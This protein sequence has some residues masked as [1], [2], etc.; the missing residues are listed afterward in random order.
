MEE[1]KNEGLHHATELSDASESD[2]PV[3]NGETIPVRT[4][5]RRLHK[6][7]T[8]Y[9]VTLAILTA[10]V[11]VL[12]LWGSAI[13]MPGSTSLSLV[14][15]PIVI[16]GLILGVKAGAFLGF[17]FGLFVF[18]WCGVLGY[19]PFT[20][21]LFA[22]QPFMTALIC[23]LKGTLAG[24]VPPLV[25][26]A[27]RRRWPLGSVILASA[28]APV[29]N[30]GIFL[31]GMVIIMKTLEAYLSGVMTVGYFIG[32]IILVNFSVEFVFNLVLSPA[33]YRITCAVV[34]Q[35]KH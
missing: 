3:V 21:F 13:P 5:S 22:N 32:A 18:L 25:H 30:T 33:I 29:C 9:M 11:V 8:R 7:K 4:T 17:A 24:L 10:L 2:Q 28:L 31:L 19:D 26:R 20:A 16:G 27:L 34:K 14:L 23:I 6:N 35:R 15:I 12:Q 1:N